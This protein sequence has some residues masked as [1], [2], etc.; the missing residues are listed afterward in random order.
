MSISTDIR[1]KLK[2]AMR[3][4]DQ[5]A[6]DTYRG[7]LSAFTNELVASGKTPQDEVTDDIALAV[8]KKTIKQRKDAISQFEA[9]GRQ[10]LADADKAQLALL[11]VFQ[12]A[13]MSEAD[14]KVIAEKKKAELGVTDTSK[15]GILVGAV[16]KETA[17]NADGQVVKRVVEGLFN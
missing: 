6:L 9:G 14:I 2:D 11:E 13:Q 7:L 3:A 17:G 4:K 8:I 10:D 5:V 16:M 15:L 12:P 1:E